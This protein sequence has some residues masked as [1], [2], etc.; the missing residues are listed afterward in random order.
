MAD[1][2]KPRVLVQGG[3][4][5]VLKRALT[6][7]RQFGAYTGGSTQIDALDRARTILA[8]QLDA[9]TMALIDSYVEYH[10]KPRIRI[11]SNRK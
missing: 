8:A 6:N 4:Q 3:R 2:T 1:R 11:F 7:H 5:R 9:D 10:I